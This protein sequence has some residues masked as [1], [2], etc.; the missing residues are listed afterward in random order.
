LSWTRTLTR[1]LLWRLRNRLLV[2]Y[3]LFGVV[4][5]VLILVMLTLASLILFGQIAANMVADDIARHTDLVYSAAYDLAL[6]TL[7]AM[8]SGSKPE[9]PQ[10]FVQGLR[11]RLP[12]L[13]AIIHS[14]S[15]A[16]LIP[17]DAEI[18]EIP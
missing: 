7:S 4:P 15:E 13:R 12:R 16:F 18:R 1:K 9:P 14:G 2:S 6:N 5:L 11:Q 3:V 10:E 17:A 8:R